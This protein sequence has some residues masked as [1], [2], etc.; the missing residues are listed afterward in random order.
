MKDKVKQGEMPYTHTHMPL[1]NKTGE[2]EQMTLVLN[3][4]CFLFQS[5][6]MLISSLTPI[7]LTNM[8]GLE[9]P[10]S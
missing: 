3:G 6:L 5:S 9:S 10:H 7:K 8:S 2:L 1:L 4:S